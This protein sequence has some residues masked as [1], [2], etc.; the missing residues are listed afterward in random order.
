MPCETNEK[1]RELRPT[2]EAVL[3][4]LRLQGLRFGFDDTPRWATAR[5]EVRRDPADGGE[6]LVAQ[7]SQP[8]GE[9]VIHAD[10]NCYAECDVLKTHPEDPRWFIEAVTVWGRPGGIKGEP[11]L[12]PMPE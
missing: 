3:A 10:G 7:W 2:G 6:A 4:E 5:F 11:R 12:L 1:V 8:R 9:L